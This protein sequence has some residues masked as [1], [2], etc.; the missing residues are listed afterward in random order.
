MARRT[1]AALVG[2]HAVPAVQRQTARQAR[3]LSRSVQ[4]ISRRHPAIIFGRS[5]ARPRR[6]G[7]AGFARARAIQAARGHASA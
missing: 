5:T 3:V 7:Q 6:R 1:H 2:P 4:N